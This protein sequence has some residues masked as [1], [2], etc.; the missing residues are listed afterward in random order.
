MLSEQTEREKNTCRH[1]PG[2]ETQTRS[3]LIWLRMKLVCVF[4]TPWLKARVFSGRAV[5]VVLA[6]LGF[7][8]PT[9]TPDPISIRK[10]LLRAR[11]PTDILSAQCDPMEL[12]TVRPDHRCARI[13]EDIDLSCDL[14]AMSEHAP[15]VPAGGT[16][17]PGRSLETAIAADN[18]RSA[19]TPKVCQGPLTR[20]LLT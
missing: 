17:F 15:Q 19:K 1:G 18:V 5:N 7:T 11:K 13:V 12:Q 4:E 10:H 14:V 20:I 2:T 8:A 3:M 9:M 6:S 16:W